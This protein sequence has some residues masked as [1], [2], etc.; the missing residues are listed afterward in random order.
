MQRTGFA[1]N[2]GRLAGMGLRYRRL[3]DFQAIG[4]GSQRWAT[5]ISV[6]PSDGPGGAVQLVSVHLKSGCAYGR[7]RGT[8]N[9]H[10]CRLLVQ[11]RGIL[12]EWID[13]MAGAD[14]PFVLLGDFNRQ[15]DQPTDDFWSD[16]DDGT[17]CL[18]LPDP[19]LGR[20]CRPGTTRP[21]SGANLVLAIMK[22]RADL[23][24]LNA[25][26]KFTRVDPAEDVGDELLH[27]AL[28]H[29]KQH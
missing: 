23:L 22:Q 1:I 18:W 26:I 21:D 6:E 14:E 2:R 25:P 16:I 11:Q 9:R 12:E 27:T 24:G 28:V 4:V 17:I 19:R 5:R 20:R 10:Q 3:P 15:L 8:V 7:L 29:Q 13:S